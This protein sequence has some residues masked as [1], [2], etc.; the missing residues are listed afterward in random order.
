MGMTKIKLL[1]KMGFVYHKAA[2]DPVIELFRQDERYD[3]YFSLEEERLR[4]FCINVRYRS[5][6]IAAWEQQ[7]YRFTREKRGF[8]IIIVGDTIRNA[9]EYGNA[10]LCFLNHGT[11]IKNILYRNLA[12]HPG[13]RYQIFVEGQYRVD[14]L[15]ESGILH[16]SQVHLIGLPKLDNVFQGRY[17]DKAVL[18]RRWGLDPQKP[19]VLFAPTYKPTCLYEVKDAIFEATRDFNLIVKLHHYSWMGRYAPHAQHRIFERRVG[20]YPH[21]VLLPA[22]EYNITPYMAAADTLVSEASSTVFDFLA[23]GKFG[24]I[25]DL[26]CE[27]LKH[28]DGKPLLTEDN[29]EFLKDAFVHVQSP[30]QLRVGIE[31][32]LRPS[33]EMRAAA[34]RERS[35]YFYQ[36]DGQASRRLKERIEALYAEGR[37]ANCP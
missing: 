35:Y 7:G 22:T 28:S 16:Q 3:V 25:Y 1:F 31:Q 8:D 18:L 23:L 36:L 19:T 20:R 24:V 6:L 9:E 13:D 37:H 29:G 2:F 34:D 33:A 11:G 14:R 10:M 21:S 27:R 26:P 30:R 5:P 12:Q 17:N 15:W 4:R 32:A